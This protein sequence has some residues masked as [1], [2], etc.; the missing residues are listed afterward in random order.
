MYIAARPRKTLEE[1]VANLGSVRAQGTSESFLLSRSPKSTPPP[2]ETNIEIAA[3][4]QPFSASQPTPSVITRMLQTKPG[5]P[6]YPIGAIRAKPFASMP[7]ERS[8]AGTPPPPYR[9]QIFRQMNHF[10]PQH[11]FSGG[12]QINV[13]SPA[14]SPSDKA[15]PPPPPPPPPYQRPPPPRFSRGAPT[16]PPPYQSAY[17]GQFQ[18]EAMPPTIYQTPYEGFEGQPAAGSERGEGSSKSFEEEGSGEF[19]GLVSYFSSQREDDLES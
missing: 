17:Y 16:A 6:G 10:R 11:L 8:P 4:P 15:T 19:G 5:Q 12:G 9:P 13:E 1:A 18:E 14:G 2:A 7:D 3:P